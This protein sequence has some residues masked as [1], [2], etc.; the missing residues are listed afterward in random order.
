MS[1]RL[2]YFKG[3]LTLLTLGVFQV[4][5]FI[6]P[7]AT[8]DAEPVPARRCRHVIWKDYKRRRTSKLLRMISDWKRFLMDIGTNRQDRR[9][10]KYLLCAIQKSRGG[11]K[12]T[13]P[14]Y[15]YQPTHPPPLMQAL[16][17]MPI[18]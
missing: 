6:Q 11:P 16:T 5:M 17:R 10:F 13:F 12:T 8:V 2:T 18:H 15:T 9:P 3:L 7:V 14:T 1:S 4:G